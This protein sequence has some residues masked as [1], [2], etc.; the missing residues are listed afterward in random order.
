MLSL[1]LFAPNGAFDHSSP[2]PSSPDTIHVDTSYTLND[3]D[4]LDL[5][6]SPGFKLEVRPHTNVTLDINGVVTLDGG[7]RQVVDGILHLVG[8]FS[9]AAGELT[10]SYDLG[11]DLTTIAGDVDG[12]GSGPS[13]PRRRRPDGLHQLRAVERPKAA[14]AWPR[15]A[16]PPGRAGSA[17]PC[18]C[19]GRRRRTGRRAR[20][21]R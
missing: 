4:R 21:P 20:R 19:R 8:T 1:S 7:D 5:A 15:G 17:P 6:G 18:P 12:D 2:Q 16:P 11:T 3:G 10:L 14:R 13:D 9:G